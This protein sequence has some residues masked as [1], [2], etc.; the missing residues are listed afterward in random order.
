MHALSL[1]HTHALDATVAIAELMKL[2]NAIMDCQGV[3]SLNTDD[4]EA[5]K[6][7]EAAQT[8][9]PH[10]LDEAI[11]TLA[12]LLAP[13]APH[14][15]EYDAVRGARVAACVLTATRLWCGGSC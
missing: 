15:G 8:V 2:S 4:G 1:I 6:E 5:S 10:V 7:A 11:R 13:M 3:G 12:V 9:A 14:I